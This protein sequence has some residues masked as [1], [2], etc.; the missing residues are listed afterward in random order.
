MELCDQYLHELL[1]LNPSLNDTYNIKDI[2]FDKLPNTYTKRY[3]NSDSKLIDKYTGLMEK[4]KNK[5]IYDKI[6]QFELDYMNES[7]SFPCDLLPLELYNI[8]SEYIQNVSGFGNYYFKDIQSYRNMMKR[9][10]SFD[11]ITQSIIDCL[12]EGIKKKITHP[13]LIIQ[14][15]IKYFND[16]IYQKLYIKNDIPSSIKNEYIKSVETDLIKNVNKLTIFLEET[17]LKKSRNTIGLYTIIGGTTY[18]RSELKYNT[19]ESMTPGKVHKI[20]LKMLKKYSNQM[21]DIQKLFKFKGSTF[22]FQ[23]NINNNEKIWYQSKK[24]IL[25]DL[26]KFNGEYQKIINKNF[27]DNKVKPYDIKDISN[28]E[29]SKGAHYIPET[30]H[31]KGTFYLDFSKDLNKYELFVLGLH[32]LVPG[33]HYESMIQMKQDLPDYI[34]HSIY[35]GFSEGWGLY[36]ESLYKS[37]NKYIKFY[38]C[39]YMIHRILRCIVETGIHIYKWDYDKSFNYMKKNIGVSDEMIHDEIMR[40]VSIPGQSVSYVIGYL[41]IMKLKKKYMKEGKNIKEFHEYI[42]N[43][44]RP[45][46][47]L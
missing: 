26:H 46:D 18:Y 43:T 21:N 25:Q 33:H 42:L 3:D 14:A 38:Q 10:Q 24:D 9:L 8:F 39:M 19:M 13:K 5:N 7:S 2:S 32:E 22:D 30:K 23:K 20:G 15:L 1:R 37:N 35:S 29:I 45:L 17:Y 41:E 16:V 28:V 47:L 36:C 40:Y 34:K 6:F 4:K 44:H 27:K 11:S 12:K 31:K